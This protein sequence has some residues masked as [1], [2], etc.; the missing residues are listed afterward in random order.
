M[1]SKFSQRI[2]SAL[3]RLQ[4]VYT[5]LLIP[6]ARV[7]FSGAIAT[8]L[9]IGMRQLGLLQAQ[10][11]WAFDQL[12]RLRPDEGVDRR[13]LIVAVTEE[14]IQLE[15]KWPLSDRTLEQVLNKLEQQQP[16]VIGLDIY[17]DFPILPGNKE[18]TKRFKQSDRIITVCKV[19]DS[20]N[21]PGIAPPPNVPKN[22]IGFSDLLVDSGGILR[23]N[24]LFMNPPPVNKSN[25]N[26]HLCQD[27]TADLFSFSLQLALNY[28]KVEKIEP[29]LTSSNELKLGSTIFK[30]LK[31]NS[32]SYQNTNVRGYQ[33]M[34]NY[35]SPR[36]VAQQVTLTEVLTGKVN[37]N[38]IKNRIVLIGT[39]AESIKDSFYTPYSAGQQKDQ[40]MLGIVI[41]AQ[42]VSQILSA[43]LDHRP[44]F[45]YWS[46]WGETLWIGIWSL[47]GGIVAWHI[48][49]PI[50]FGLT[51]VAALAGL[52]VICF[53]FFYQGAWIPLIPPVFTFIG[54]AGSVVIVDRF[55]KSGYTKAIYD[56]LK[57]PF[58]LNIEIDHSKKERQVAQITQTEYFQ[59]L[60]KKAKELRS[61]KPLV[62]ETKKNPQT[63]V[64]SDPE[65]LQ[66]MHDKVK[67]IKTRAN[68][69]DE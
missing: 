37:P 57:N 67:K 32:G 18:L 36:H 27:S 14:D 1:I 24:L 34:L 15:K 59:D 52:C 58:K 29:K 31:P 47:F 69:I 4:G 48:R 19:N 25:G 23:R 33:V 66:Q 43:V 6:S 45:W 41:H 20:S 2:N 62:N 40:E 53:G 51:I 28:L 65:Y 26:P 7:I 3:P 10:E 38:W 21:N 63:S 11:L 13:L 64:S 54:T 60:R 39:T 50:R 5:K 30:R 55:N 49:H 35:R 44:L 22:R 46:D 8:T 56:R 68:K 9:V 61:K 17:R 42:A 12:V 16:R